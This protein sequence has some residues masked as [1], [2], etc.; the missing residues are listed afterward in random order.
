MSTYKYTSLLHPFL[1]AD[2]ATLAQPKMQHFLE[3]TQESDYN[4]LLMT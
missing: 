3:T 4:L 1:R 2:N